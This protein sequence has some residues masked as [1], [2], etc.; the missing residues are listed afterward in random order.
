MKLKLRNAL[1][2]VGCTL[3]FG[4]L[5]VLHPASAVGF[6]GIAVL[7]SGVWLAKIGSELTV[8]LKLTPEVSTDKDQT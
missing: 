6:I 2:Y 3:I 1:G 7:A 4:S 5:W 8:E